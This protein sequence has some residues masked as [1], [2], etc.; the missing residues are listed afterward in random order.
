MMF[1]EGQ[2]MDRDQTKDKKSLVD[3]A[4]QSIENQI[5]NGDLRPDQ[6]LVEAELADRLEISRTPI[7]EALRQLEIK[8]IV[9]KRNLIGYV[10]VYHSRKDVQNN[11][12]V[13]IALESTAIKLACEKATQEHIDRASMYLARLDK[14]LAL[15]KEPTFNVIIPDNYLDSDQ[16]WNSLFHREIYNAADNELLTKYIKNVRDMDRLK[17]VA[18][19]MKHSDFQTFQTQHYKILEALKER[20]KSKAERAVQT[21]IKTL[22]D[23]HLYRP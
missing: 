14:D 9:K 1:K 17:Q 21:H 23:F 7:R 16:D 19:R 15:R 6:R 8:G 5:L 12:E 4:R 18:L 11:F 22:Y 2:K 13:R 10:V 3:V 20:D